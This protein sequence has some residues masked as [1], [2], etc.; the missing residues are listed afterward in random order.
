MN[1]LTDE[2]KFNLAIQAIGNMGTGLTTITHHAIDYFS[3]DLCV[4]QL[5][6]S[7]SWVDRCPWYRLTGDDWVKVVNIVPSIKLTIK[8]LE[9]IKCSIMFTSHV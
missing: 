4:V 3:G 5:N 8:D 9:R 1:E 2:L 6:K 7:C